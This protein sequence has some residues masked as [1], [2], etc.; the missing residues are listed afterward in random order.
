MGSDII[1]AVPD[2]Y[3][4]YTY[5]SSGGQNLSGVTSMSEAEN[6]VKQSQG[7]GD[8]GQQQQQQQQQQKFTDKLGNTHNS[9]AEA[10]AAK[11][12][13]KTANSTAVIN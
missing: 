4:G 8:G 11:K 3:G 9:Q 1:T 7:G 5:I 12:N 10:D 6:K 13:I 2:N